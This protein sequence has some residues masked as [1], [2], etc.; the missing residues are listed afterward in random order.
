MASGL[1]IFLKL[2]GIEGESTDA[3]HAKEIDVLSYSDGLSQVSAT[4]A[5]SGGAGAGRV[6]FMSVHFRKAVDKASVPILLACA[7]GLHVKEA[8]FT[9]RRTGA[10]VEFFKIKL[11][12]VVVTAVTQTAGTGEQYPLSFKALDVGGDRAGFLDDVTLDYDKIEWEY[13][14]LNPTGAPGAP[15]KGGWDFKKNIKI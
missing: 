4:P 15:V 9:F 10:A 3:Q 11:S 14:P 2:D 13:R 5:G 7:T 1:G 6:S 8:L 12:E